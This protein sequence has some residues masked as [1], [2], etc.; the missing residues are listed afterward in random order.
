MNFKKTP[1]KTIKNIFFLFVNYVC[2]INVECKL[3]M[4]GGG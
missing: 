2:I 1:P 3:K 4:R